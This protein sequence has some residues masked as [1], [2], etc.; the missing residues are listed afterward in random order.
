MEEIEKMWNCRFGQIHIAKTLNQI[1]VKTTKPVD[2]APYRTVPKARE[3]ERSNIYRML[4]MKVVE[5]AE[6]E[7]AAPTGLEPK[8]YG[9]FIFC[10]EYR[11]LNAVTEQ[12]SY[13]IPRVDECIDILGDALISSTLD[14]KCIYWKVER[15]DA[16]GVRSE[17]T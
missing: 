17:F 1:R 5:P 10:V 4:E 2:Y 15:E 13:L 14:D 8:N 6:T 16:D 7:W 3:F 11:K 9:P 12:D